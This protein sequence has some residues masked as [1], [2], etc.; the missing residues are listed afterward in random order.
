MTATT[1]QLPF[2]YARPGLRFNRR[3]WTSCAIFS[4]GYSLV[5]I[6][7]TAV[8][9]AMTSP[10]MRYLLDPGP[11]NADRV[12][13]VLIHTMIVPIL[14]CVMNV[15]A[16]LGFVAMAAQR[17]VGWLISSLVGHVVL[18]GFWLFGTT[19]VTTDPKHLAADAIQYHPCR[20]LSDFPLSLIGTTT[21]WLI[22]AAPVLLSAASLLR[23]KLERSAK[24]D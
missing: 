15:T 13:L 22:V 5:M 23:L 6:A 19:L 2:R 4:G 7:L 16:T 3:W 24:P 12:A 8:A 17:G 21:L 11:W 18:L 20:F 10:A 14:L 9:T 1:P